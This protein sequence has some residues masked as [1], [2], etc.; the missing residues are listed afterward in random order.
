MITLA[1]VREHMVYLLR[2]VPCVDDAVNAYLSSGRLPTT[3]T[4]CS[5]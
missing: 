1:D 4:T 3:D 5:E 2:G